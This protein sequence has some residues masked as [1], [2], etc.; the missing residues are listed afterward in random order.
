MITNISR[1]T[2]CTDAADL[3][4]CLRA[5]PSDEMS[6]VLNSSATTGASYGAVQDGDWFTAPASVQLEAGD[7]VNVPYVR[8]HLWNLLTLTLV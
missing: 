8:S 2:G 7:F 5:V 6:A 3:L 4:T 1:E